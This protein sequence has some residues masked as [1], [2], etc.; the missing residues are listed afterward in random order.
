MKAEGSANLRVQT[1]A[2]GRSHAFLPVFMAHFVLVIA[3]CVI[4]LG[5]NRLQTF[6]IAQYS[7][8]VTL[9][10]CVV[11]NIFRNAGQWGG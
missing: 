11:S 3:V 6:Y 5:R 4:V 9:H 8:H 10:V 7:L 2:G 1:K